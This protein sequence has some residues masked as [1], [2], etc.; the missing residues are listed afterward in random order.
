M[1]QPEYDYNS[2]HM[3]IRASMP[4]LGKNSSKIFFSESN[5]SIWPWL[6][7]CNIGNVFI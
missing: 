4:T 6:L 2:S 5:G 1:L 3:T 7:V